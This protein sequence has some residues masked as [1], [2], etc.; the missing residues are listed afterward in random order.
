MNPE[1]NH[2]NEKKSRRKWP[3]IILLCIAAVIGLARLALKTGPVQEWVRNTVVNT[4][5]NQLIPTLSVE[6]ISGDLWNGA[7]LTNIVLTDRENTIVASIDTLQLAYSPLSYFSDAFRIQEVRLNRP[8]VNLK[9]QSDST[10]NVQS[11]MRPSE[12]SPD[13]ASDP[14]GFLLDRLVIESGA[15]DISMS[16]LQEDSSFVIEDINLSGGISYFGDRYEA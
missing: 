4:A 10:W 11:W 8:F 2:H 13:T 12:A 15:M 7:T 5:N 6:N 9:Q 16:P 1:N 3:W 14:F